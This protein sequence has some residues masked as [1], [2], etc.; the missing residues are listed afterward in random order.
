M[1]D[2]LDATPDIQK[3]LAAAQAATTPET[4]DFAETVLGRSY[5]EFDV[6]VYL[7]EK[8]IQKLIETERKRSELTQ[9]LGATP[10]EIADPTELGEDGFPL[11][12]KNPA[13][14]KLAEELEYLDLEYDE[15]VQ[16]LKDQR[17]L[18]R[19]TGI[20]PEES[21]RIQD[22][23]YEAYPKEFEESE[24]PLSGAKIKT[25]K[26]NDARDTLYAALL[27]QAHIVSITAPNGAKDN[28]F[29]DIEKVIVTFQRLPLVARAKIDQAINESTIA[30][31][32]YDELAD[33]VF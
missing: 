5:P 13:A 22:A 27:R 31:D 28:S 33:E 19:I 11:M 16:R 7:D 32:F 21:I 8:S 6:P 23:S 24:H 2:E 15:L 4:F 20:A 30:V 29:T 9:R 18:V 3:A 10:I 12:T 1:T 14:V 25:E 17:Y 26:E